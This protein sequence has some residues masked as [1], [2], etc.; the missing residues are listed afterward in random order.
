MAKSKN[1]VRVAWQHTYAL[2]ETHARTNKSHTK[3]Y[4]SAQQLRLPICA[5]LWISSIVASLLLKPEAQA[6]NFM[7]LQQNGFGPEFWHN[8]CWGSKAVH[9]WEKSVIINMICLL[10]VSDWPIIMIGP[11]GLLNSSLP[12]IYRLSFNFMGEVAK[13]VNN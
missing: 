9:Q 7:L 1:P 2:E 8:L 10:S 4:Y 6:W 3:Y 5:N 13:N 11:D 12:P